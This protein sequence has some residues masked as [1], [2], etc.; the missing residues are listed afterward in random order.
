MDAGFPTC[1]LPRMADDDGN[2]KQ[3]LRILLEAGKLELTEGADT[4][5]LI[6]K[7]APK[8]ESRGPAPMR[9]EALMDWL[10]DRDEVDEI[11]LSEEELAALLDKW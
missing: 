9:A 3:F 10:I 8:L 11:Y 6:A 2:A 4:A 1:I 7:L 5:V